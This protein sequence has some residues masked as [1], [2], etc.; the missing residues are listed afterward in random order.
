MKEPYPGAHI[1]VQMG[2]IYNIIYQSE[3]VN[4]PNR[5]FNNLGDE[6]SDVL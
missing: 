5:S 6:I 3:A 2:Q 1:R 4:E